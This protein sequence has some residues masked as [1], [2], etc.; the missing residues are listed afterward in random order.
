MFDYQCSSQPTNTRA[1]ENCRENIEAR[2][3]WGFFYRK[4]VTAR[5]SFFHNINQ[6]ARI[7]GE[8][9]KEEESI[10]QLLWLKN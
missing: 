10:Y 4:M 2:V 1:M 3:C 8:I 9:L 7:F 6:S 5:T